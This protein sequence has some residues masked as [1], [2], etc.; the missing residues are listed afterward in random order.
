MLAVTSHFPQALV[1]LVPDTGEVQQ[2]FALHRPAFFVSAKTA[3]PR[4]MQRIHYLT[5]NIEL[6]LVV[7]GVADAHRPG[8]FVARKPGHFPFRQTPLAAQAVH[9]LDLAWTARR[10]PQQPLAPLL[11]LVVVTGVHER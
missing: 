6:K 8:I 7:R 11:R 10:S 2:K 3:L 1:R 9:G 4:L 5:E